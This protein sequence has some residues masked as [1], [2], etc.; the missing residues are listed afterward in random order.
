MLPRISN[1]ECHPF[2]RAE[3]LR[4]HA[5]LQPA[6]Q[7]VQIQTSNSLAASSA[8]GSDEDAT[9]IFD[10]EIK[11]TRKKFGFLDVGLERTW[12]EGNVDEY[13]VNTTSNHD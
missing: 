1:K 6:A 9:N 12:L 5:C 2:F 13:G 7:H 11:D 4:L 10:K 3:W 8:A